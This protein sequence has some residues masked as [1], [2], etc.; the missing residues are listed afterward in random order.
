[1]QPNPQLGLA[2]TETIELQ[3]RYQQRTRSAS[4]SYVVNCQALAPIV[5]VPV[6]P[7]GAAALPDLTS[8]QGMSIGQQ[9]APWG[10]VINLSEAD[11]AANTPRGCQFR[12]KYDVAN[13]RQGDASGASRDKPPRPLGGSGSQPGP[14]DTARRSRVV[15]QQTHAHRTWWPGTLSAYAADAPSAV[16]TREP[17]R[18]A[19]GAGNAHATPC[20]APAADP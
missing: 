12:M 14:P 3:V 11:A 8:H 19:T 5:A 4:A 1:M 7:P 2:P 10:G 16:P 20:A 9:S 13:D 17:V 15:P 18:P 6:T